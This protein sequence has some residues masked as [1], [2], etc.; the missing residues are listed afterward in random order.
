MKHSPKYAEAVAARINAGRNSG[1]ANVTGT[2]LEEYRASY[3]RAFRNADIGG[4]AQIKG[5]HDRT[6]KKHIE[7]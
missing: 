7:S 4:D 2:T 6:E 1:L 5:N 3:K